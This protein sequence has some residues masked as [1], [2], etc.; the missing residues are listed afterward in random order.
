MTIRIEHYAEKKVKGEVVE[1][2][3]FE[4][5]VSGKAVSMPPPGQVLA[6]EPRVAYDGH[7]EHVEGETST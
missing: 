2:A 6:L 4:L 1:P 7:L 5:L 3:R